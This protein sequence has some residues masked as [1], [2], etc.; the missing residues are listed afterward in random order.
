[1]NG[2]KNN[3]IIYVSDQ[4]TKKLEYFDIS[5]QHVVRYDNINKIVSYMTLNN[6]ERSV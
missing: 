2:T 1:M 5:Q 3:T 6:I 4:S